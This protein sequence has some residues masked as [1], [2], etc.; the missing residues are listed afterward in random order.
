MKAI[1]I[2]IYHD[3]EI[4][5]WSLAFFAGRQRVLIK[6]SKLS[7]SIYYQ[8]PNHGNPPND[9]YYILAE[10]LFDFKALYIL[11]SRFE[12]KYDK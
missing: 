7:A 12:S 3:M 9:M 5:I 2:L 1:P 10:E 11:H 4:V 6:E 8:M